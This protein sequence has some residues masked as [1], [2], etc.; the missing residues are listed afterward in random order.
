MY[1]GRFPHFSGD[2]AWVFFS[3][4]AVGDSTSAIWRIHPDG[5]SLTRV[6]DLPG[7]TLTQLSVTPDGSR[8]VYSENY[9]VYEF[10]ALQLATGAK[11]L[12]GQYGSFP[13]FSP[14]SKRLAYLNG[15]GITIANIDGTSPI[16]VAANRVDPNAGLTWTP[17]G[18]WLLVRGYDG[19]I[20]VS[21]TT[22]EVISLP[23]RNFYQFSATR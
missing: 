14:D 4:V 7:L 17:D 20:L 21:A 11:V 13:E 22:G 15:G 9:N 6:V 2:G 12:L 5:S 23:Y 19:P 10:T 1:T 3:G 18:G 8:I 16:T